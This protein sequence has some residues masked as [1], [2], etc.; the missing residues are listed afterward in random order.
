MMDTLEKILL[1][2][3]P[4]AEAASFF[5]SIKQADAHLS[6]EDQATMKLAELEVLGM[7]GNPTGTAMGAGMGAPAA[8][9]PTAQ[10]KNM[11]PSM[12]PALSPTAMGQNKVG[13]AMPVPP[14]PAKGLG[15]LKELLMGGYRD[16]LRGHADTLVRQGGAAAGDALVNEGRL[17]ALP[18]LNLAER[19][20]REGAIHRAWQ[21]AKELGDLAMSTQADAKTEGAKVLASRLGAGATGLGLLGLGGKALSAPPKEAS[22]FKLALEQMGVTPAVDPATQQYLATEQAANDQASAGEAAYLRQQLE[23]ARTEQ[24]SLEQQAQAATEQA[25]QLQQQQVMH[26]QQLSA[27]QAQVADATSKAMSAQDQILQQQQAAAAMRMA[28]QQLRGTLLQA[29]STD[30]PSLTPGM[31]GADAAQAAMSQAA[32]PS[33]APEPT[34][35]PAGQASTPG[36]PNTVAPEGDAQ[37]SRPVESNE[38]MFGNAELTLKATQKEPQGDAK[39]PGKEVLSSASP[40][41][42]VWKGA[43][44]REHLAK[45]TNVLP[46]AVGGTLAGAGLGALEGHLLSRD[47]GGA[48]AGKLEAAEAKTD[49]GYKDTANLAQLRARKTMS[50]F[51]QQ[52]P[53]T[54]MGAGALT[55]ALAGLGAGIEMP[56]AVASAKRTAGRLPGMAQNLKTILTQGAA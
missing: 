38:P 19:Q 10:G 56:A 3:I 11:Q 53:R 45:L 43:S 9:P 44:L 52:H 30:P 21:P 2:G 20:A 8:L 37:V 31:P 51:A 47:D 41:S 39:T 35:G 22:A 26:D 6:I 28:Y 34:A 55:G 17:R 33:S 46:Y 15:R 40:F 36:T 1:P 27:Y 32:G 50:D 54:M 5:I 14:M 29:A 12:P 13:A 42:G 16:A 23:A 48:L 18:I 7:G 4:L 24:Q 49:P 25:G